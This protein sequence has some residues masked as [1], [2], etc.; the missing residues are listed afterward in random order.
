MDVFFCP[1]GTAAQ[2][3]LDCGNACG[4]LPVGGLTYDQTNKI[5]SDFLTDY[6]SFLTVTISTL[7]E[8]LGS[9][10]DMELYPAE[11]VGDYCLVVALQGVTNHNNYPDV[12]NGVRM[13]YPSILTSG[14]CPQVYCDDGS[15]VDCNTECPVRVSA[16]S[17]VVVLVASL[18][19]VLVF[20]SCCWYMG[21]RY[22]AKRCARMATRKN[23]F[24]A[25]PTQ[26]PQNFSASPK[27]S[28][29]S[30]MYPAEQFEMQQQEKQ[31]AAEFSAQS[32][33]IPMMPY[34][35]QMPYPYPYPMPNPMMMAP[36]AGAYP[37]MTPMMVQGP[38][39][40][41]YPMPMPMPMQGFPQMQE[42]E[43]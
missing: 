41:W 21:R 8:E 30:S 39:G 7:Y 22:R 26:P 40:M 9:D 27:Q 4:G 12:Y 19:F 10:S 25:L 11:S 23:G 34:P 1:D 18:S 13:F 31:A 29:P 17:D 32:P 14:Y 37:P 15:V 16:R 3:T 38:N 42:A 33:V 43:K 24:V 35:T 28:A 6:S 20:T 5:L 36:N 2:K